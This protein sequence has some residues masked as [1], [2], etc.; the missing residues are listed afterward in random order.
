MARIKL[1]GYTDSV[2]VTEGETVQFMLSTEGVAEVQLELVRL[3]HGDEHPEGPG[4]IEEVVPSDLSGTYP[5]R[6]QFVDIGTRVDVADPQGLLDV[7]GP[8]TL[9][10]FVFPTTPMKG[11]QAILSRWAIHE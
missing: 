7:Q 2:S 4:F 10:A 8:L 9:H 5:V 1:T 11:R 3:I 6:R